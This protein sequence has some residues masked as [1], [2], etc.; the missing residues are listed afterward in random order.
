MGKSYDRMLQESILQL[1][2]KQYNLLKNQYFCDL[3][4]YCIIICLMTTYTIRRSICII[5]RFMTLFTILYIMTQ[6]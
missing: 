1:Y 6:C 4:L 2:D 5:I 3:D